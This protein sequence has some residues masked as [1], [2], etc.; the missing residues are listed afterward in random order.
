[1]QEL[2]QKY[3]Q[4]HFSLIR[5]N[6][7]ENRFDAFQ[8]TIGKTPLQLLVHNASLF[9]PTPLT[10]LTPQQWDQLLQINTKAPIFLTQA[11]LS[12]LKQAESPAVIFIGDIHGEVTFPLRNYSAYGASKAALLYLVRELALELAPQ[13][14]VNAVNPGVTLWPDD[15]S[16]QKQKALIEQIPLKKRNNPEDLAR[17]ILFLAQQHSITGV[18][19]PV[20][21]G[22]L[23]ARSDP[24]GSAESH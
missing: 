14:R 4:Q 2:S 16:E 15:V 9:Y 18:A 24:R 1:M 7:E 22:R 23:I 6:L 11:L 13:I 8:D 19:L 5:Q 17:A 10:S 12:N 3:P 21:G 20:D